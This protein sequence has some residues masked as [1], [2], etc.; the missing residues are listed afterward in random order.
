MESPIKVIGFSALDDK[1]SVDEI[2]TE[3]LDNP[4][5]QAAMKIDSN[6]ILAEYIKEFA[7]DTYIMTRV[8]VDKTKEKPNIEVLQCEAYVHAS[9]N[10]DIQSVDIERIDEEEDYY[11]IC[12]EKNTSMQIIFWL[13]NVIEYLEAVKKHKKCKQINIA[14][15]A[16]E[17]TIILP[18]EKDEED[19]VI[20]KEE[21]EKLKNI[22][23]QMKEG[24]EEARQL[25]EEEEKELD[26]QLKQRLREE[27]FLT[28]MSGYF[29][30]T[31]IE[32]AVYAVLGEITAI[33]KRKNTKTKENLYVFDLNV[34]EMPLE[35]IVNS[36]TLIGMPSIGMRFMGTCWVQGRVIMK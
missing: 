30:P 16:L 10:L 18:V 13:Q 22:L 20:E 15:L 17:G 25:L 35:V 3:I 26:K 23:Q 6:R 29:I 11:V 2:V 1:Y 27:D 36:K 9:H 32:D 4:T 21:R 19:E 7:P 8:A 12:E 31:T 34:N 33:K 24:D 14:A 5:S 28:I